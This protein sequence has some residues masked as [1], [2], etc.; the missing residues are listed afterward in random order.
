MGYKTAAPDR[1]GL[2]KTYARENRKNATVAETVLWDLLR[3]NAIGVTFLRQHVIGDY[4][5]DFVSRQ[6]GL[7]IE[8]DG[9][10]HAEPRQQDD[11][12]EREQELEQMG[13]HIIRFSNEEV[14]FDTENVIEQITSYF[15]E[16]EQYE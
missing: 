12:H 2:L 6:N 7:I 11:D 9:G 15:D 4:I 16:R 8:V 5:V 13:Y 3:N 10:Y 1:Y 14:L